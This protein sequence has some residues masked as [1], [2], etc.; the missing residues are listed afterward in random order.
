LKNLK[1]EGASKVSLDNFEVTN[2]KLIHV[3][4]VFYN[5]KSRFNLKNRDSG[6]SS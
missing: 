4:K 5:L 2:Y 1:Q 6:L 3:T